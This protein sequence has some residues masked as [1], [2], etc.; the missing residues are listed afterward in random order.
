M[1]TDFITRTQILQRS[2]P[3]VNY[4]WPIGIDYG[5]SSI[6]GFSPNKIFC[7]PNCAMKISSE[8]LNQMLDI[9]END[10]IYQCNGETWIVGEKAHSMMTNAEAMNYESEMYE[11]NRYFSPTFKVLM[12]VGRLMPIRSR[13][14]LLR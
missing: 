8:S 11:R 13:I 7:F 4:F 14:R 1:L 12:D 6:K 9:T 3:A 5:F 2:N 10:M